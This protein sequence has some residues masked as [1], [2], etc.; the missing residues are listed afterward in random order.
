MSC[1]KEKDPKKP[2]DPTPPVVHTDGITGTGGAPDK[3]PP[4]N[5][6]QH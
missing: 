3:P 1:D 2:T 6:P 5:T 4:T